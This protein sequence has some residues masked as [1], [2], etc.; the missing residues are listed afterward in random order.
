MR[1]ALLV[2]L[3]ACTPSTEDGL[4]F[5]VDYW[6]SEVIST[7][8]ELNWTPESVLD[9]A[10]VEAGEGPECHESYP[11]SLQEDGSWSATL[12]GLEP[13]LSNWI[14]VVADDGERIAR[15]QEITVETEN[16]P[17]WLPELSLEIHDE[18][19]ASGGFLITSL[20]AEPSGPVI[21]DSKG[22]YVWWYQPYEEAE[23]VIRARLSVD[24]QSIYYL[25]P[26]KVS[27]PLVNGRALIK[28]SLD[29]HRKERLWTG[30]GLHHDFVELPD[31]VIGAIAYDGRQVEGDTVLGDR[32]VELHPDGS[33]VEIWNAWDHLSFTEDSVLGQTADW[34]HANALDFDL[35]TDAYTLSLHNMNSIWQISRSG[36]VLWRLG[37]DH[38]DFEH[39]EL[40]ENLFVSQHQFDLGED[41]I[42]VFD[43]GTASEGASR[44]VQYSL[45]PSTGAVALLGSYEPDPELFCYVL[46]DVSTLENDHMRITWSTAGRIEELDSVGEPVWRVDAELGGA[47]GYTSWSESLS[48]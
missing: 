28:V 22:N 34:T 27:T 35:A 45:E 31:G 12:V 10:W 17:A 23:K 9:E 15:S 16:P 13:G 1:A 39:G 18:A 20:L 32:I 5:E 2:F 25:E 11:A 14:Q 36:E 26:P 24:A 6:Q 19:R 21:I 47:F 3:V 29:G 7:V 37:G 44:V 8:V 33:V 30:F 43:N 48:Y 46:G 40:G 38:T 42:V 41:G 4:R